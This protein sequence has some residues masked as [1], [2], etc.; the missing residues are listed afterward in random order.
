VSVKRE[1]AH[2]LRQEAAAG[3]PGRRRQPLARELQTDPSV[4]LK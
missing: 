1:L 4:C 3:A 2:A